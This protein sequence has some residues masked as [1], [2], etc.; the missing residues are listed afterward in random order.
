MLIRKLILIIIVI[1]HLSIV[2]WARADRYKILFMNHP[3]LLINGKTAKVGDVFD[4]NAI[5]KWSKERQ[6]MKVFNLDKKKQM[7]IVAHSVTPDG[8]SVQEI[9][10][11]NKHLSTHSAYMG[12]GEP[13]AL[14]KLQ[15]MFEWEYD[16]LDKVEVDS[17]VPLSDKQYF[18]ATYYYGDTRITKRLNSNGNKVVFDRS[19]FD[20]DG[21]KL[22]PR[23]IEVDIDYFDETSKT[24]S[25]VTAG[26]GLFIVPENIK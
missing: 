24:V 20:I 9:L 6:A 1:F 12:V 15:N 3:K 7:L 14:T 8:N 16:M 21:K 13:N 2:D 18:N 4:D 19:L 23:D 10:S 11:D 26:I 17:P 25:F 22:E 5:V